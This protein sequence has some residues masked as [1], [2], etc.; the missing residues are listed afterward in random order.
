MGR[1][2]E[3]FLFELK[4]KNKSRCGASDC[5]GRVEVESQENVWLL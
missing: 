1:G 2:R 5:A 4:K 3:G